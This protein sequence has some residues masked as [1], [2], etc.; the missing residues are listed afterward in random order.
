MQP[1]LTIGVPTN[2]RVDLLPRALDAALGQTVPVRVV[3]ADDSGRDEVAALLANHYAGRGIAYRPNDADHAWPNWRHAARACDT[4]FFAWL[5]DDDII[6]TTY[7]ERIIRAFDESKARGADCGVYMARLHCSEAE[8]RMG[9]WYAGNG[10]WVPMPSLMDRAEPCHWT[11]GA[12][13]AA[14][15]Y[16]TSWSL[17]P[18][19]AYRNDSRFRGFL[20]WM[21]ERCD[22]FVERLGP[23]Y[24]ASRGGFISDP[25]VVGYWVQHETNLSRDQWA[26]QPR[27]TAM[28]VE[29]LDGLLDGTPGWGG[30][31]AAWCGLMPPTSIMTWIGQTRVTEEEGRPSK[32]LGEIRRIMA[33]SLKGRVKPVPDPRPR[34]RRAVDRAIGWVRHRAAL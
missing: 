14:S 18:A 3:V 9:S 11:Q 27:Q 5:Q 20:D 16:F 28:L 21:P 22:I 33:A 12:C 29:R 8:G 17:S 31:F 30:Q 15:G 13:V 26:D 6:A 4:E 34:W 25:A 24:V 2:G 19:I 10:P 7:A 32:H 1:R 23:A